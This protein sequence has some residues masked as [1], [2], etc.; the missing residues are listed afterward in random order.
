[1]K[2]ILISTDGYSIQTKKCGSIQEAQDIMKREYRD[3][4]PE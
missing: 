1:M 3:A 2:A 4:Y